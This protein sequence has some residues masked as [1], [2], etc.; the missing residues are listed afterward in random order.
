ME[1]NT[2]KL[3]ESF[4]NSNFKRQ[5]AFL[6]VLHNLLITTNP[7]INNTL[8]ETFII[9]KALK[10]SNLSLISPEDSKDDI[11]EMINTINWFIISFN[12]LFWDNWLGIFLY[13]KDKEK[14][15][16]EVNEA[17]KYIDDSIL[18]T[19]YMDRQLFITNL[20]LLW[21]VKK[22]NPYKKWE[23]FLELLKVNNVI[24]RDFTFEDFKNDN[25]NILDFSWD[26]VKILW[27]DKIKDENFL[28]YYSVIS[29]AFPYNDLISESNEQIN[30]LKISFYL[31]D[32]NKLKELDKLLSFETNLKSRKEFFR[33]ED[34]QLNINWFKIH[35]S[36]KDTRID[37]ILSLIYRWAIY[38]KNLDFIKIDTI[39][40][41]LNKNLDDY[42]S[43]KNLFLKDYYFERHNNSTS[44]EFKDNL[45]D[46]TKR[47]VNINITTKL[48]ND[49]LKSV[50]S[51]IYT[52]IEWINKAFFRMT[53]DWVYIQYK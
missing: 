27:I 47:L 6:D 10:E 44:K 50:N 25:K 31:Y 34:N 8:P 30:S 17:Y 42:L 35:S 23:E 46:D 48:F 1:D 7:K 26:E 45:F 41:I 32:I 37:N 21:F 12:T 4:K 2:K 49:S 15:I 51:K 53:K 38:D 9:D 22:I 13:N 19:I 52:K 28:K 20:E 29:E 39:K 14:M 43:Y 24:K 11:L 3:I 40:T 16:D 33:Y 36:T 5:S 18:K